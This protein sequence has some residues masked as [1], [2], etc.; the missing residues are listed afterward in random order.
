[1]STLTLRGRRMLP[2]LWVDLSLVFCIVEA[3]QFGR[4]GGKQFCILPQFTHLGYLNTITIIVFILLSVRSH[5]CHPK[6]AE[7]GL[8]A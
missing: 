3:G 5:H 8:A 6:G 7:K 1:M 4:W 2:P